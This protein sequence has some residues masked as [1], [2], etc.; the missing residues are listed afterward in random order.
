[1]TS[2]STALF[3]SKHTRLIGYGGVSASS[4]VNAGAEGFRSLIAM[5]PLAAGESMDTCLVVLVIF[6]LEGSFDLIY[7]IEI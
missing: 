3:F 1:V 6:K 5:V 7:R 4:P 2:T